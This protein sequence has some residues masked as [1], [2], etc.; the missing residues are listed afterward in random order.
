VRLPPLHTIRPPPASFGVWYQE[1]AISIAMEFMDGGSLA[2]LVELAGPVPEPALARVARS[3]LRAVVLLRKQRLIHRD[4]KP[5][6]I[7]MNLRCARVCAR[8]V[9]PLCR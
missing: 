4:L 9:R 2:D 1:G 3:V 8:P 6:N 7:L 5:H